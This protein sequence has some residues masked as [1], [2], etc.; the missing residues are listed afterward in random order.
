MRLPVRPDSKSV[1]VDAH[2]R[3][4]PQP[5]THLH[6]RPESGES[7]PIQIEREEP[8][9]HRSATQVPLSIPSLN[10]GPAR[11][12]RDRNGLFPIELRL[13]AVWRLWQEVGLE[14]SC[15]LRE[16]IG[17]HANRETIA[18]REW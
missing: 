8:D 2:P 3:P 9:P 18:F 12:E 11:V 7:L 4:L 16:L 17:L 1:T 13:H 5:C 15:V 14:F 10:S 6:A